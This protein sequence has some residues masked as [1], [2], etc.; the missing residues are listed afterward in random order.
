MFL[1]YIYITMYQLGIGEIKN[2]N[3]MKMK[4]AKLITEKV[5]MFT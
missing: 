3:K 1:S 2:E 5:E 4:L